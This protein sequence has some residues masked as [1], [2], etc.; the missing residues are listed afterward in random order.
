MAGVW[1]K[2]VAKDPSIALPGK[3]TSKERGVPKSSASHLRHLVTPISSSTPNCGI[4]KAWETRC[5]MS[6]LQEEKL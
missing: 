3:I 2:V 1:K 5:E 4:L 6:A